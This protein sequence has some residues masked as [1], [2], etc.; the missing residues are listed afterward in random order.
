MTASTY[1]I[2]VQRYHRGLRNLPMD[3]VGRKNAMIKSQLAGHTFGHV[4]EDKKSEEER[5][6]IRKN[7][8]KKIFMDR[9][10]GFGAVVL[11]L[12]LSYLIASFI[13]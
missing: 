13:F 2:V 8:K 4:V 1:H 10:L 11:V 12:G 9:V 3:R 7:L 6:I 5:L